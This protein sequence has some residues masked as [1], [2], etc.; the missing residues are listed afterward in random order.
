MVRTAAGLLVAVLVLCGCWGEPPT[1]PPSVPSTRPPPER[2]T[3]QLPGLEVVGLCM[4]QGRAGEREFISCNKA[5]RP[6]FRIRG[7]VI[8]AVHDPPDYY[9]G[10]ST[11]GRSPCPS[12]TTLVRTLLP[13]GYVAMLCLDSKPSAGHTRR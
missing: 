6:G 4:T 5:P 7:R 2:T 13:S 12:G 1:R 10:T 3:G 9:V 8:D 11:T